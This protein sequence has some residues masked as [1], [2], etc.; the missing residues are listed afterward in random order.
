MKIAHSHTTPQ[1][2]KDFLTLS[3]RIRSKAKRK[4]ELFER[5]CFSSILETHKLKGVLN[6][7]WSFAIDRDYRVIFR[8]LP[9]QEVVYYRIGPHRIYKE[10]ER[11]F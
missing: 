8:F 7:F 2:E 9:N 3:L 1:F 6:H 11:L 4:I 5:D 10:L